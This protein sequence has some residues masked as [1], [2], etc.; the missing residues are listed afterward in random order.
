MIVR[1]RPHLLALA[2]LALG[3]MIALFPLPLALAGGDGAIGHSAGDLADHYWGTWWFAQELLSGR[4]PDRTELVQYPGAVRL[5][6]VDPVGG[7]LG[8]LFWPLGF[9]RAYDAVVAAQA[10]FSAFAAYFIGY[11]W[12]RSR[13]AALCAGAVLGA[14]PYLIGL[15]HS[16]L[17]EYI[18]LGPPALFTWAALRAL[19]LDPGGAA[20]GRRDA[21]VAGL[22]LTASAF[23]AFYY[24]AFCALLLGCAV[25]GP[26]WRTRIG[27]AARIGAVFAITAAPLFLLAWSSLGSPESAITAE[28]APGWDYKEL[29]ATDLLTFFRWGE[30]YFPDTR[31]TN[32]GILHVN[33][34]GWVGLALAG[35]ALAARGGGGRRL[36]VATGLFA[37]F[38]L[39]PR[40]CVNGQL[41]EW[42]S[43]AV[44]LPAALLYL[45]GSPFRFVHHPYRMVALLLPLLAGL[46]ALG[47]ARLPRPA[48]PALAVAI[49][50][51][52]LLLS[53]APWPLAFTPVQVPAIYDQLPEGPVLDWPPDAT[54][55]NR[56]YEMWQVGHG[57]PIAYGVNTFL[58]D[59]LRANADVQRLLR[60][61]RAP[62]RRAR[63]RDVPFKGALFRPTTAGERLGDLGFRAV[64]LHRDALSEGELR[65][66]RAALVALFGPSTLSEG[67]REAWILDVEPSSGP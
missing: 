44:P 39:G 24:A 47:A 9:P 1:L 67:A 32:P 30:H 25:L 15:V 16:G 60:E 29:P 58:P 17:T 33:H 66:T 36:A 21:L 35:L 55:W 49:L 62:D 2:A 40:L 37:L 27:V 50:A 56:S 41:I 8:V 34:L 46:A 48:R 18:G 22:L 3:V 23:Q 28:N 65:D 59:D 54:T 43:G 11:S 20:P 53:P 64:V 63:N 7:L 10:L 12:T 52:A 14:S 6:Y 61:L 5:W 51:E 42:G 31:E 26:G 13:G 38:T 19:A 57:R 4:W 45:P